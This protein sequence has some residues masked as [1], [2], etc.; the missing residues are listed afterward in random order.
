MHTFQ[1]PLLQHS[2]SSIRRGN[3]NLET[4]YIIESEIAVIFLSVTLCVYLQVIYT[5]TSSEKKG[6]LRYSYRT[7]TSSVINVLCSIVIT[8][9]AG[10]SPAAQ[11]VCSLLEQCADCGVYFMFMRYIAGFGQDSPFKRKMLYAQ[12]IVLGI[13]AYLILAGHFTGAN[14]AITSEGLTHGA[15]WRLLSVGYLWIWSV[16]T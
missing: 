3:T 10:Y 2:I 12:N 7:T 6:L 14:I 8:P 1:H 4:H 15:L 13:F 9:G 11:Y 5:G 16:R